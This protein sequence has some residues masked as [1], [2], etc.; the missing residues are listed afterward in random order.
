MEIF[1]FCAVL[2]IQTFSP[3]L[4]HF[5]GSILIWYFEGSILLWYFRKPVSKLDNLSSIYPLILLER[6]LTD[7]K[8]AIFGYFMFIF[9]LTSKIFKIFTITLF[10]AKLIE[11][12]FMAFS[13]FF[14]F[15][16]VTDVKFAPTSCCFSFVTLAFF[17]KLTTTVGNSIYYLFI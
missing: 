9:R 1:I 13:C 7:P 4:N 11:P 14:I 16:Y 5:E 17:S 8:T 2:F 6:V 10:E 3:V 12:P 15:S